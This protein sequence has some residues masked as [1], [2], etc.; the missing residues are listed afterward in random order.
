M[1]RLAGE[2]SPYLLQHA[3]NPVD[4]Y[5]Y[6]EEALHRAMAEDKPILVSVGYAA[7]HWCHVMERESFEQEDVA[8]LMNTHFINIK[9][10]REERPDL[11]HI[12]MDALQAMTGSGGWPL[13]LFLTPDGRPFFGGTYFPPQQ[14]YG[15]MS[16]M[17][18]LREVARAFSERRPDIEAQADQLTE[19]L[20]TANAFGLSFRA[21]EGL[22]TRTQLDTM[23]AA[24]MQQADLE[25]GGFGRPPKFPQTF[26]LQWLI[27]YAHFT[28]ERQ[29]LEHALSSLDHILD[30]GI[31]DQLGG[32]MARYSTDRKWLVPHFEK[33]LYDN[34]LLVSVLC[35]AYASTG[36]P[37][38]REGIRDILAFAQREWLTEEGGFC[39]AWDADSE[40]VEGKYYT[41]TREEITRLL[42]ADAELFARVFGVTGEG[43][44]EGVNILHRPKGGGEGLTPDQRQRVELSR[45]TLLEAR[46]ARIRP[47]LD[48]KQIL[49]WNALMN[50]AFSQ[51]FAVTGEE[52]YRTTAVRHMDALLKNY[53]RADGLGHVYKAGI[54]RHPAFLDDYA[55]LI[56]ALL[57][58]QEVTADPA[59]LKEAKRWSEYVI[60]HFSEPASG[61]FYYTHSA[62]KDVLFRKKEV[63]DGATPSGNAVM[64]WN[65]WYLSVAMDQPGWK[66]RA[67]RML[68]GVLSTVTR[69]PSS[70]GVWGDLALQAFYGWNEV[71]IIGHEF[72]PVLRS[73]L[74]RYIPN[75]VLQAAVA[76]D[77]QF[78]LLAG[79]GK[80]QGAT[81]IYLCR[82]YTCGAPVSDAEGLIQQIKRG[83]Q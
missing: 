82:N 56:Q 80:G 69:Y 32:G 48:D 11:D 41:W 83:T 52:S 22:V 53:Q 68:H 72:E 7:C 65:L 39:A 2:S 77:H 49:S 10:D 42:G 28:G 47:L 46:R 58:L 73:V 12:Y 67:E 70:F 26:S 27:R 37:R 38:F 63:Y 14:A 35:E 5:P 75:R 4:W 31:Y 30:G 78:P 61:F 74:A 24:L 55:Y 21:A 59:Y 51:A 15:R 29:G 3:H 19:H 6:G 25:E 54:V 23:Y 18:T 43:N 33:M 50:K 16:W 62:Q 71:A 40:G 45:Q 36:E 34:A 76:E 60:A 20:S 17:D 1:N 66:T 64:A 81:W 79:K 13:N 8:A 44:W 57:L 9:I